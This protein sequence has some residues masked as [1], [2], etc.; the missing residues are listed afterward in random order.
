MM[1]NA[2][3]KEWFLA[4][5]FGF[6]LNYIWENAHSVLYESYKGLMITQWILIRAAFVDAI[7]V[8]FLI[9]IVAAYRPFY[10]RSWLLILF[11]IV[12]AISL[13][14][15]GLWTKRW[16]YAPLMP[17]IPFLRVGL[18]PVIQLGLTAYMTYYLAFAGI[19]LK[20]RNQ[21]R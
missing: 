1:Q 17:I 9:V 2:K 19:I 20:N 21:V 4:F 12:V 13:E 10:K 18:T 11:G 5:A 6:V 15:F 16:A 14:L 7:F 3:S 8:L